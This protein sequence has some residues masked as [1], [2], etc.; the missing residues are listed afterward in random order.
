M[1]TSPGTGVRQILT[2]SRDNTLKLLD[3]STNQ[4]SHTYRSPGY[5]VGT[6]WSRA[7]FSPDGK[8]IAS[9]SSDGDVYLWKTEHDAAEANVLH[10]H[11]APVSCCSW[12]PKGLPLVSA[13]SKTGE[14][15]LWR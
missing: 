7:C 2:N 8:Q 15:I 11:K 6:S 9:G 12:S 4:A 1:L 13:D 3:M 5:R 10:G 14:C